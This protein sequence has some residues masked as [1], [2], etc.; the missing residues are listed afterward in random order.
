M[1]RHTSIAFFSFWAACCA[2]AL[3]DDNTDKNITDAALRET[4]D[5]VSR[6][7]FGH[8]DLT[9]LAVLRIEDLQGRLSSGHDHGLVKIA[10]EFSARRNTTKH[11]ALDPSVFEPGN[12][13]CQ[14]WLYLH[15]G[16]PVGHVF[17]GELELLLAVD[18][19]GSWRAVSPHWRSRRQYPLHGYLL[20]KGREE[21]GYVLFPQATGALTTRFDATRTERYQCLCMTACS[22]DV[23]IVVSPPRFSDWTGLLAL[24]RS[25]Y[26][27]MESRI[28]PPSSLLRV[29]A[30]QLER[31][32]REEVLIL[33]FEDQR[34]VGCAFACLRDDCVYVGKLAVAAAVRGR[35]V[36]RKIMQA[37][38]ALARANA[39][40]F[41]ELETR[42]ELNENHETF[43][44]LGFVKVA[45]SAHPGFDRP[46][47][48]TMR[49]PVPA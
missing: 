45:E 14:G 29:D 47:S 40:P 33:A 4:R 31:K 17:Q 25:A 1:L 46:T 9:N 16:I 34:L 6:E 12:A 38:E 13:M 35:G 36:A 8:Y 39:R 2:P 22:S 5:I 21:E 42:I 49:K 48:I 30:G 15:C 28:D 11:P 19:D 44:A 3:A 26:A 18:R 32:A 10:L 43:A 37:A 41:V 7:L 24:L 23:R 20:L 27:Y